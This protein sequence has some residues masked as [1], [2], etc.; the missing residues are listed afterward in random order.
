MKKRIRIRPRWTEEET[1]WLVRYY[2]TTS[3]IRL[4]KDLGR[5]VSSVVFKAHRMNL[6]KGPKR[7][8]QMGKENIRKRWIKP[9][10]TGSRKNR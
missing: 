1:A 7:L 6:S 10:K 5:K 9:K 8:R 3:N 2:R 4:A